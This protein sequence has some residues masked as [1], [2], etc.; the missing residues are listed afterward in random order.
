MLCTSWWSCPR[1]L[2]S[3]PAHLAR[4]GRHV[5]CMRGAARRLASPCRSAFLQM[6][7]AGCS[8]ADA[9][10][11]EMAAQLV[12]AGLTLLCLEGEK[13]YGASEGILNLQR[14]AVAGH[15]SFAR[16]ETTSK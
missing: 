16:W 5:A 14:S 15:I 4:L 8:T 9:L 11:G 6:P 10:H 7:N 2:L 13:P 3:R 1:A 12:S